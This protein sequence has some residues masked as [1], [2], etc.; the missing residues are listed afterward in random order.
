MSNTSKARMTG[1]SFHE[2]TGDDIK[3]TMTSYGWF[4]TV[5][6]KV[7]KMPITFFTSG[8]AEA[9]NILNNLAKFTR[10]FGSDVSREMTGASDIFTD[11]YEGEPF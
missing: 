6:I 8:D 5:E 2:V 9:M 4:S 11:T 7:G 10:D 3:V 1:T